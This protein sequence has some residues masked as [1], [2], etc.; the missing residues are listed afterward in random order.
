MKEI[1]PGVFHWT[2]FHDGIKHDVDSYLIATDPPVL[3]DPQL[4]ERGIGALDPR[5][6]HVILTNRH[7]YRHCARIQQELEVEVWCHEA[8]LHEFKRGESV[9]SFAFGDELPG[10]IQAV[11]VGVLCPE[12]TALLIPLDRGVLAIGDAVVRMPDDLCF[13]PDALIGEDPPA[14]KRGLRASLA[15]LLE[16]PFEHLLLAHGHPNV[17]AGK[18]ELRQFVTSD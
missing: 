6:Q 5:P 9:T 17:G 18:E 11:E 1:L 13:V 14:I 3:I 12:E 8:G 15:K 2:T 7:H 16:L 4:P 10:G